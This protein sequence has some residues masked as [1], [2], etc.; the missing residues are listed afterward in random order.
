MATMATTATDWDS[1]V[2]RDL[3]RC[4]DKLRAAHRACYATAE[5]VRGYGFRSNAG[6]LARAAGLMDEAARAIEDIL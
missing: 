2:G 4:L 1:I 6:E 3:L 5:R